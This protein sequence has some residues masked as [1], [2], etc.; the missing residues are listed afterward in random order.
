MIPLSIFMIFAGFIQVYVFLRVVPDISRKFGPIGLAHR[1]GVHVYF[2]LTHA[3]V[4][5]SLT[6]ASA[7]GKTA[8]GLIMLL[9]S[10]ALS[11]AT[12]RSYASWLLERKEQGK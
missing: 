1:V 8:Q 12:M 5:S 7:P 10:M 4:V 6:V 11:Y 3:G 9:I 2:L